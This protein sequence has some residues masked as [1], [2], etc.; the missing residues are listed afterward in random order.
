MQPLSAQTLAGTLNPQMAGAALQ[1]PGQLTVQQ[2]SPGEQRQTQNPS[3][4]AAR[5]RKM[6]SLALFFRKV[7][8]DLSLLCLVLILVNLQ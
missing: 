2:I 1:L 7:L 6:G 5:P 4:T 3:A 8:F